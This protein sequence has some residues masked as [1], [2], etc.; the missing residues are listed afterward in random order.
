MQ[1]LSPTRLV[2]VLSSMFV[3]AFVAVVSVPM[4]SIHE[5]GGA[6]LS[7]AL[8]RLSASPFVSATDWLPSDA[9]RDGSVDYTANLQSA[10]D[11]AAGRTLVL[12]D[13]PVRVSRR[14]G[15]SSCLLVRTPIE[16]RGSHASRL[17]EVQGGCPILRVENA[18]SVRL[19]GFVLEG[20]GGQGQDLAHGLLHV[21]GGEDVEIEDVSVQDSDADGIAVEDAKR[22]SVRDC[23]VTRASRAGLRLARCSGGIVADSQVDNG[24]GHQAGDGLLVGAGIQM[25]SSTDIT[26]T[27]NVVRTGIGV[28]ILLEADASGV[29]PTGCSI[30]SNRVSG[31]RNTRNPDASSGIRLQNS[32]TEKRTRAL[33]AAN[34]VE[35]CGTH[36]IHVEDQDGASLLGNTIV[37]SDRSS[38]SVATSKDVQVLSNLVLGT[39]SGNTGN[40]AGLHLAEGASG[41]LAQ[42][43]RIESRAKSPS[44]PSVQDQSG[45]VNSI[46][47][48]QRRASSPPKS[49]LWAR[50]DTVWNS[51]PWPGAPLGWVCTS[52]GTPGVWDV[53]GRIE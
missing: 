31:W 10:I 18:K 34:T 8:A 41:V 51:E 21:A 2:L 3:L 14:H 32:A 36:G 1:R 38:I 15:T 49:G 5:Q 53:F 22:V 45:G 11:A 13:F 17:V 27:G 26:C 48:Q 43:N 42:G 30:V 23:R 29:A 12:P 33:V 6:E 37:A 40:Q 35:R 25:S 24:V 9:V 28:G 39:D 47:P 50:G 4:R 46:E 7:A 52:A 20:R 16:I 19:T 44:V